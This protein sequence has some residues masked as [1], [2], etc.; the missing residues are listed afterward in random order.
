MEGTIISIGGKDNIYW[1]E[2]IISIGGKGQYILKRKD[3]IYWRER[4]IS[5]EEKIKLS[6]Q[7]EVDIKQIKITKPKLT[8]IFSNFKAVNNNDYKTFQMQNVEKW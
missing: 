6:I 1:R 7:P 5:V 4:I 2:R 8:L 3:N